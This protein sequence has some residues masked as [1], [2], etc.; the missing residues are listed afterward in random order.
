[1]DFTKI[2]STITAVSI[3]IPEFITLIN[4]VKT[5]FN[6]SDQEVLQ[7]KIAELEATSNTEHEK[8]QNL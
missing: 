3:Q 7:S 4:E 1:M 5:L 8:S 6:E 2:L